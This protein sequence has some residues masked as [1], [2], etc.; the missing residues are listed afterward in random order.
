M[1]SSPIRD[2]N[3]NSNINNLDIKLNE[4]SNINLEKV[5]YLLCSF[6]GAI[7][8]LIWLFGFEKALNLFPNNATMKFNTAIVFLLIGINLYLLYKS[9]KRR[10]SLF[11][12]LSLSIIIIGF[13]SFLS[14]YNIQFLNIDNI[15]GLDIFSKEKPGLMSAA[16]ATCSISIGLGFLFSKS[17]NIFIYKL[18]TKFY[19]IVNLISLISLVSFFL[20]INIDKQVSFLR[21]MSIITSILF[22]LIS[23]V[24]LLKNPKSITHRMIY[25]K[26]IGS[27]IFRKIIPNII[28]IPIILSNIL[29]I[30]INRNYFSV[31]FGIVLFV[32]VLVTLGLLYISSV[33]ETLN[34][35]DK[36][37]KNLEKLSVDVSVELS[38]F[39]ETINKI[40][41][42]VKTDNKGVISYVNDTFCEI[43]KYSKKDVYN[44]KY[45]ILNSGYH[46]QEFF[47]DIWTTLNSGKTWSGNIRNKK[48]DGTFYWIKSYI[49]PRTNYLGEI[50]EFMT[51][52]TPIDEPADNK[53]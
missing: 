7:T 44:K 4:S 10:N 22:Y 39:K 52:E 51:I 43:T 17:K 11:K 8:I 45:S 3:I 9:N 20:L 5:I 33:A 46:N 6:I 15:F 30:L 23:L 21:S 48:K 29:L 49:L 41:I 34:E 26:N 28:L 50:I 24:L 19:L 53:L 2:L 25:G 12:S 32:L 13:L 38:H 1:N 35:S 36:G 47:K 37:R 31:E 14:N 40:A 42:V 16:T 18:A 27:K